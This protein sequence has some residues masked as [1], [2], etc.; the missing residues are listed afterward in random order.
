MKGQLYKF[1]KRSRLKGGANFGVIIEEQY[2]VIILTVFK[3]VDWWEV[4][5][6]P[7]IEQLG[8]AV[9]ISTQVY[10]SKMTH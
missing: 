9:F 1:H 6:D 3:M 10:Y 4:L 5:Q 7:M 2:N 8:D